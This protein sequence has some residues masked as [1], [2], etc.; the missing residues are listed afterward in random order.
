MLGSRLDTRQVGNE[1][2]PFENKKMIHIDIDPD[3]NETRFKN[4]ENI[5]TDVNQFIQGMCLA[6]D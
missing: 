6:V 5:V 1:T 4:K 2:S 3:E